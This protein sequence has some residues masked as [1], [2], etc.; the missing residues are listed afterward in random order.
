[1]PAFIVV[2]GMVTDSYHRWRKTVSH[3]LTIMHSALEQTLRALSLPSLPA[4]HTPLPELGGLQEP[5]API[6]HTTESITARDPEYHRLQPAQKTSAHI[7]IESLYEL[8]RLR[9]LRGE[10]VEEQPSNHDDFI[11]RGLVPIDEAE[12]LFHFYQTQLDPYIYGLASKYKTLDSLRQ[13]SSLLTACICTVAASHQAGNGQLYETCNQEFRRLVSGS[14]FE[15]RVGL[16]YLRALV[17]GSYWLSD[18]SWTL[19]GLAVRRAS[20]INLHK[21]YYRIIDSTNGFAQTPDSWDPSDPEASIDPVRLW[22]LLYICDQH[23]SILYTRAPMIREDDTIRGWR[24]YLESPH[25][26]QSDIRISSQVALMTLLGQIRE[27]FGVDASKPIPRGAM[28]HINTFSHHLDKWL[29]HWSSKLCKFP[30][31]A[32]LSL[33]QMIKLI[34]VDPN[35]HIGNFPSKGILLHYHFGKLHLYSHVFRGLK[36]GDLIEH[37]PSYFKDAASTAVSHATTILELLLGDADIRRSIIGVPH[38]FH[39]MVAFACVVLLKVAD[40]YRDDLGIDVATTHSLIQRVFD[41]FRHV[42]CGQY[43]LVPW[44]ADGL[45]KMLAQS[46]AAQSSRGS[47]SSG[48]INGSI[49]GSVNSS[50]SHSNV[51]LS[52]DNH[53]HQPR[54]RNRGL[55]TMSPSLVHHD[56][57][58]NT[59]FN[60][61]SEIPEQPSFLSLDPNFGNLNAEDDD[62]HHHGMMVGGGGAGMGSSGAGPFLPMLDGGDYGLTDMSFNFV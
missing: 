43:H 36:S 56:S 37:I 30:S 49:N 3:D 33:T 46:S 1:M 25:A 55:N 62:H 50:S 17:I 15:R 42:N 13:S 54:S 19:A 10:T 41:F 21:F 16:D 14:M 53:H 12:K 52:W 31:V 9:S 34:S 4:L 39:T 18:V 32:S 44:M 45:A 38:Y 6:T 5:E 58:D 51:P 23:L 60:G 40:R 20:D 28:P 61:V 59:L 47:M 7:P 24:A 26:S 35:E 11:S 29:A 22:Y 57:V 27:F 48:S 8:T 2:E